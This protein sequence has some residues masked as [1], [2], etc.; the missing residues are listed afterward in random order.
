MKK[1]LLTITLAVLVL[2]IGTFVGKVSA[3]TRLAKDIKAGQNLNIKVSKSGS[4]SEII[5]NFNRKYAELKKHCFNNCDDWIRLSA[6][7]I[8]IML[9][10]CNYNEDSKACLVEQ[11]FVIPWMQNQTLA[12]C[13]VQGPTAGVLQKRKSF[14]T[15]DRPKRLKETEASGR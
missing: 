14:P 1:N 12:A 11:N 15:V 7:A 4:R 5:N 13:A 6:G 10:V 9:D 8:D 3:S 2:C